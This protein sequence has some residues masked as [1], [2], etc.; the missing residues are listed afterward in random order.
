MPRLD[1]RV[2]SLRVTTVTIVQTLMDTGY[3]N[4]EREALQTLFKRSRQKHR[5]TGFPMNE[6]K[7]FWQNY[8]KFKTSTE[9]S[10]HV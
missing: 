6:F 1:P 9:Y 7:K 10:K 8:R 2:I 5:A 3:Y 4:S